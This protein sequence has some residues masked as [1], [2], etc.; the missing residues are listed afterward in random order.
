MKCMPMKFSGCRVAAAKRV[1]EMEEVL[2]AIS[3]VS[4]TTALT[5][6]RI[7]ILTASFSLAASITKS[8]SAK[9]AISAAAAIRAKAASLSAWVIFSEATWRSRFLAI[10]VSPISIWLSPISFRKTS[11][12]DRAN[13]W[14]M[15]QPIWPAPI[16]ATVF[17]SAIK[18][19]QGERPDYN[20]ALP[21]S[22]SSSGTAVNKS[23]TRP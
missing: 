17:I 7:S 1:I 14:A 13:T 23:A 16:I 19:G 20:P 5:A 2:E 12:P 11:M 9:R 18:G 10:E 22:S 21:S 8:A 15:P 3:V 6:F 4:D